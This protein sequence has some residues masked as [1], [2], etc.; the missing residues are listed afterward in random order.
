MNARFPSSIASTHKSQTSLKTLPSAVAIVGGGG[1]SS[2][3]RS[4]MAWQAVRQL[5]ATSTG[6]PAWELEKAIRSTATRRTVAEM[7]TIAT[8]F[9]KG[10]SGSANLTV[11]ASFD[12]SELPDDMARVL[13]RLVD[14]LAAGEVTGK[15]VEELL[16]AL[17]NVS[18]ASRASALT[19]IW[20]TRGRIT[21]ERR[22]EVYTALQ[23]ATRSAEYRDAIA[24]IQREMKEEAAAEADATVAMAI[25]DEHATDAGRM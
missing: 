11:L 20:N 18:E 12:K 7:R 3:L 1:S 16:T 22:D 25:G 24:K 17:G 5:M 9:M 15:Q 6:H 21:G 2:L 10:A 13:D 19:M 23:T 4:P 14:P 8:H